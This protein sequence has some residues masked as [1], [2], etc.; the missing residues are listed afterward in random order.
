VPATR[1]IISGDF[2]FRN[3]NI[4]AAL[5]KS[6]ALLQPSYCAVAAVLRRLTA[7]AGVTLPAAGNS[8]LDQSAN[9]RAVLSPSWASSCMHY[10]GLPSHPTAVLSV[11]STVLN[12]YGGLSKTTFLPNAPKFL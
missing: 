2:N 4:V 12:K 9:H 7:S 8:T 5:A 1:R 6:A 10:N 11:K 3:L